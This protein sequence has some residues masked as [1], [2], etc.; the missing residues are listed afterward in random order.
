MERGLRVEADASIDLAA[1]DITETHTRDCQSP[2]INCGTLTCIYRRRIE[3]RP[4]KRTSP[5]EFSTGAGCSPVRCPRPV[6]FSGSYSRRRCDSLCTASASKAT[7]SSRVKRRS[8]GFCPAL[9][10]VQVRCRPHWDLHEWESPKLSSTATSR[11][12]PRHRVGSVER[13]CRRGC[14][15][16]ATVCQGRR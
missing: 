13:T 3:R 2:T 15:I 9:R 8:V 1:I 11:R 10:V 4:W 6:R 14:N 7:L 16:A 5:I 12:E